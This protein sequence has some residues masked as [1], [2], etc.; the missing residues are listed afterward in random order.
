MQNRL[1]QILEGTFDTQEALAELYSALASSELFLLNSGDDLSEG[2]QV[3]QPGQE[4]GLVHFEMDDGTPF[5]PVF[6]SAEELGRTFDDNP[7]FLGMDGFS[8]F[9][10]IRGNHIILNPASEY[11]QHLSPENIED[12]IDFAAMNE[13]VVQEETPV[14]VGP[15]QD[16][17]VELKKA[18][19]AV[20]ER[21][22]GPVM[23][24]YLLLMH[25]ER[26]GER[27]LLVGVVFKPGSINSDIFAVAG[28]AAQKFI[29]PGHLLDFVTIDNPPD[30]GIEQALLEDGDCFYR[31]PT[32][33]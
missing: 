20:F 9:S 7:S 23:S 10:M 28:A 18:V 1:E 30:G 29:P 15:P 12:L 11:N 31:A 32:H 22:G 17:P 14:L 27:S 13:I 16:D 5:I 6:T 24:A 25:N 33:G 26:S 3:L 2:H 19:A 8:L 4:I 21:G